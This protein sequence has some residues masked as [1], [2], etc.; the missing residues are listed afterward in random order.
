M[1]MGSGIPNIISPLMQT[2]HLASFWLMT[3]TFKKT[4]HHPPSPQR[5]LKYYLRHEMP[6]R[7]Q[8]LKL[9]P[10]IV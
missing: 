5:R 8:V 6:Q 2:F 4:V 7:K 3:M 9:E 10:F 1:Q